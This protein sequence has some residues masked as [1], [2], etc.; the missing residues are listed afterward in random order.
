MPSTFTTSGVE[1]IADGEQSG[2]WGQT[3]NVNLQIIDRMT[4][5]AGTITLSG[6]T[7]TLTVSNGILSD[8]QYNV[9]VF[10]GSPSGTNTVTISP[11]TTQ[12]TFFVRNT[13]AQS[14]VLT[15]GSGGNVT[16][17]AGTAKIVYS[18]GAGAGAQV[19]DITNTMAVNTAATLQTA[20]T[21]TIGST[22]KTFDGSANV[23]WTLA[24]IGVNNATL[25][26]A[27]SGI[28]TGSQTFTANQGTNATFT[29]NVPATNLS[30]TG[31][32][33][34]GPTIN[35]STGTNATIPT[36]SASAS[37]AVTT[38]DQTFAG[39]KTFGT[40]LAVTGTSNAAGRFYAGTTNPTNTTRL[41]YDGALHATSFVGNGS[42]LTNLPAPPS[43]ANYQVF[44]SSGTWTKPAGVSTV[45]VEVIGAG[46]GGGV[47]KCAFGS[48]A[49]GAGGLCLFDMFPASAFGSTVTVTV[50]AGGAARSATNALLA[51]NAGGASSFGS[52]STGT[53]VTIGGGSLRGRGID[54]AAGESTVLGGGGGGGA[55]FLNPPNAGFA[56]GTSIAHGNGGAGLWTGGGNG[57]AASGAIPGGGGGAASGSCGGTA[58]S[59]AGARGEVRVWSW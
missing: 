6:T 30:V 58:T 25:T 3:T 20:R 22:G 28:A 33:T 38:G 34:A 53:N 16:V 50:G 21:F 32:T 41:N 35:S 31:G 46:G 18:N 29:V 23:A 24:E 1:L 7:H 13:T 26:L 57:T 52:F 19:F 11:N 39:V 2:A 14:V 54:N 44:T 9:L 49:G 10:A 37:G 47:V 51:G 59:G 15:Q 27:T 40:A 56:A 17:L 45:F 36:A 55:V 8:G 42:G 48:V 43:T 5:Q 4:S 12:R